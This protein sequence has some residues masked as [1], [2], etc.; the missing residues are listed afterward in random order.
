VTD[1][2]T[3]GLALFD[4]VP[5]V[6]SSLG[7]W[8][9]ARLVGTFDPN[10]GRI[11]KLGWV[12]VSL[13]GIC[14]ATWKLILGLTDGATDIRWLDNSLFL[15]MAAGFVFF[16]FAV[17]E[18]RSWKVPLG[19]VTVTYI[20]AALSFF[21]SGSR[22]WFFVLLAVA[23]VANLIATG[24]LAR[25][26]WRIGASMGALLFWLNFIVILLLPGFARL[27]DQTI[28]L[29]WVEQSVNTVGQLGFFV[30]SLLLARASKSANQSGDGVVVHGLAQL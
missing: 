10:V 20:A 13:G 23:A 18:Q 1:T 26:S 4:F 27:P 29:Q 5:V 17:G 15:F 3:V 24:R 12:L 30:A 14:K 22:S 6:L 11:A 28:A 16:A 2:Y 8:T 25:R 7:L 9:I 19:V 21:L